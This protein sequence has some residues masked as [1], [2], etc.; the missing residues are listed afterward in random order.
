MP[1]AP[2]ETGRGLSGLSRSLANL[3]A[4][5]PQDTADAIV[6]VARHIRSILLIGRTMRRD[7]AIIFDDFWRAD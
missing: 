2:V 1:A 6:K 3:T 4:P 5:A 7:G